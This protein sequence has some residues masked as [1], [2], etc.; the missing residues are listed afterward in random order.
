MCGI[1]GF[2]GGGGSGET[3]DEGVLRRMGS[4]LAHRGPDGEGYFYHSQQDGEGDSLV[5][6][7]GH[8]RLSII[9]LSPAAAQPMEA[10]GGRYVVIFNGEIYNYNNLALELKANGYQFNEHSDTAVIAPLYDWLGEAMLD[11]LEGMFAFALF[12]RENGEIFC[13]RDGMGVKPFYY[14][15]TEGNLAFAS[16]L[17]ALA[18]L[19]DLAGE[20]DK[21]ALR[22]YLSFGWSP[23]ERTLVPGVFKLKP[24]HCLSM[25][26]GKGA[27][28]EI[29]RWWRPKL[30]AAEGY[31]RTKTPADLR[32]FLLNIVRE[33]CV[34]DVLVGAFLSGGVDSSAVVALMRAAGVDVAG[35]YCIAFDGEGMRGEGFGD[36]LTFARMMAE[37]TGVPL[38]EVRV[39]ARGMLDD[40]PKLAWMLDEPQA[41]PA[42]LLVERISREA[43][44]DGIKVLMSGTGG[45]DVMSGYRRHL[46][47]RLRERWGFLRG[48]AKHSECYV[49]WM[50]LEGRGTLGRRTARL[51]DLLAVDDEDFL[52]SAFMTNMGGDALG[53]FGGDARGAMGGFDNA[54]TASRLETADFDMLNR[55]LDMEM[56][57]FLP[58]HNFNYT[59]KASMA[60]GVEVRV[61]LADRRLVD[62]MA[63]VPPENKLSGTRLKAF[64]KDAM[65]TDIPPEIINR[66]KA[67][68]GAPV[69]SWLT[70][71]GR[72]MVESVLFENHAVSD[73]GLDEM[74]VRRL[75]DDTR[76]GR[77]D[78]AY[79]VLGLCMVGWWK[80]GV[81]K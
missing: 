68:F 22:D 49:K 55:M 48:I 77:V 44:A 18:P 75:W 2:F 13:A 60:A 45:D 12:D 7:L 9:D 76:A 6:G 26:A 11:K 63:D 16:E 66:S 59:D 34:S 31:D 38:K 19:V 37:K 1:L 71:N 74:A 53:L 14:Y 25:R 56:H 54:L 73:W 46:A 43:R 35:T 33:Q 70:D 20:M 36:D 47:V 17:K 15:A 32:A 28:P 52:L 10:C 3:W 29:R 81:V 30:V 39:D 42:P 72:D 5:C 57:G 24:G 50:K 40:L 80:S 8:R 65:S 21:A 62:W 69:R 4:L 64:F 79:R 51:L 41:D 58:D 61:P 78:G 23:G 67:G 27:A